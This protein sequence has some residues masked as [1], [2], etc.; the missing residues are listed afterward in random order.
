M[1]RRNFLTRF[2]GFFIALIGGKLLL[3]FLEFDVNKQEIA[4]IPE[5]DVKSYPIVR[6]GVIV[7]KNGGKLNVL[8]SHCTH[9]GCILKFD[10]NKGIFECPCHG[11]RFN[12]NGEVIYGPAKKHL[13]KLDYTVRDGKILVKL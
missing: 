9:L 7:W 11:S 6:D 12:I 10:R 3:D 2:L 5:T 4:E 8:S 13:R 1:K